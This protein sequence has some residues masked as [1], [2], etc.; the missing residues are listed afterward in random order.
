MGTFLNRGIHEFESAVNSL[1]YV[2][3]TDMVDYFNKLINT[4]QRYACISRPRRFGKTMDA[5]MLAAYYEKGSDARR[6]F[7]NQKLGCLPNWD[8]NLN[9]YDVIR[10]DIADINSVQGSP[11]AALD[12]IEKVLVEELDE[13]YPELLDENCMA[14]VD[15]LDRINQRTGAQFVIII[16]EWDAFFRDEK[17]DKEI[18][19]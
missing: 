10:I 18:E 14:I 3:K 9:K 11:E 8:K 2:D 6:L 17:Y 5:N 1:I 15:A 16:D 12:Y 13:A 7:E 4:E 19:K